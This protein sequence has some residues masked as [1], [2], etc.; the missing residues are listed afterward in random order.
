MVCFLNTLAHDDK[1]GAVSIELCLRSVSLSIE[2]NPQAMFMKQTHTKRGR[3]CERVSEREY[4]VYSRKE[5]DRDRMGDTDDA[6][7]LTSMYLN[8][9]CH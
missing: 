2:S 1:G 5:R 9:L 8:N 7:Q 3:E 4:V 6:R